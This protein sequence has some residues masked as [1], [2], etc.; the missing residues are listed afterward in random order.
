MTPH[1]DPRRQRARE[2]MQDASERGR[3]ITPLRRRLRQ[4]LGLT[5]LEAN[6]L[7]RDLAIEAILRQ[8]GY[9]VQGTL[10]SLVALAGGWPERLREHWE[11]RRDPDS[12]EE[13]ESHPEIRHL[14]GP[15]DAVQERQFARAEQVIALQSGRLGPLVAL[16]A[17]LGVLAPLL[18]RPRRWAVLL[19]AVWSL[20]LLLVA[21]AVVGP[22]LRY[23]YPA[24]PLLLVLASGGLFSLTSWLAWLRQRGYRGAGARP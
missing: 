3:F 14:L 19:P 10:R 12:R 23:R 15:P 22:V 17:L 7:M 24:D 2:L 4:E 13:W 21:V 1:P 9:Y 8:P 20:I 18:G 16:L 11:T 6:A 5:E